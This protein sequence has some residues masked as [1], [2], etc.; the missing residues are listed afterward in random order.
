MA[1]FLWSSAGIIAVI[2]I[3]CYIIAKAIMIGTQGEL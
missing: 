3:I 2:F 1:V